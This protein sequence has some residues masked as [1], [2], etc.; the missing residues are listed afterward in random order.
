MK[1]Y[2][3]PFNDSGI[4]FHYFP[5]A[6]HFGR[7]DQDRWLPRLHVLG[8][9]WLV[10]QT[11]P[12]RPAPDAFLQRLMLAD[13]EP[14]VVIKPARIGPLDPKPLAETV[15]AL[16]DSGVH[17]VVLFDRPNDRASW[18]PQDWN[19][20]NLVER[21]VDY[22]APALETVSGEGLIPVLPPLE[23][24][25]AYWDTSFLESALGS[26]KRRGL[27]E[28][29]E[30]AAVGIRNFAHNRPLDW[31]AGGPDAWPEV[32]PY[33]QQ[34]EG[35]DHRGFRLYEWYQPVIE[36]VL[37]HSLPMVVCAN[38]PQSGQVGAPMT[39]S[40]LYAEQAV[41]MARLLMAG[42]LPDTVLNNAF[43]L[44]AAERGQDCFQHSWFEPN[45]QARLPAVAALEQL[46]K[47]P[48]PG[49]PAASAPTQPTEYAAHSVTRP[50]GNGRAKQA[51]GGR[52]AIE[53]YLLLPVFEWGVTRW[54]LSIIQ[55]YMEVFRPTCGFSVDEAM[56]A[57]RVTIVGNAQG[58]GDEDVQALAAAGCVVER[59]AGR[60]GEETRQ[61]LQKLA[62][63]KQ[64]IR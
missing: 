44:L 33:A 19:K 61:I 30:T 62:R 60:D 42:E 37:G 49:S 7:S 3:R 22:L 24:L 36:K 50:A 48:R 18:S 56:H 23:P 58:V 2:P 8:A 21:F 34:S 14:V 13:I 1:Q 4:G 16:A 45:G 26:L 52:K 32:R 27:A 40:Q 9:S 46:E 20:P 64:H 63:N 25:G 39:D 57:R 29:L 55:E 31:G 15:R 59:I 5:D 6:D 35:Q 47:E 41:E 51:P 10:V 38:G 17:Y 53:H 28:L 11:P 54:H 12:T 43:W